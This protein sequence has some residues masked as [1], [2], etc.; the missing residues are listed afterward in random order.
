MTAVEMAPLPASPLPQRTDWQ[1][2][3]DA[4]ELL[5]S[6]ATWHDSAGDQ[7]TRSGAAPA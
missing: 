3:R 1:G 7:Q 6:G 4:I 2:V 5:T